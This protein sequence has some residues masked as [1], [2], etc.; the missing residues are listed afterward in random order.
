MKFGLSIKGKIISLL[1]VS[2]ALLLLLTL[3]MSYRNQSNSQKEIDFGFRRG[4]ELVLQSILHNVDQH[5]G[6]ILLKIISYDELIV[7]LVNP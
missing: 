4:N 3:F 7:F 1:A 5:M 2:I 6:K